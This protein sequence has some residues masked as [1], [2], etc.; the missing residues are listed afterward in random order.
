M[1][2]Q[3]K[4]RSD[5][6]KQR[7]DTVAAEAMEAASKAKRTRQGWQ[8]GLCTL[9]LFP[10]MALAEPGFWHASKEG[11]NLWILGSI[12]VGLDNFYPLPAPIE[13]A[14]KQSDVLILE[15]DMRDISANESAQIATMS[16]LPAGSTLATT[17]PPALYQQTLKQTR[18]Y[19]L[20][21]AQI[22]Q[23]QP[24]VVAITLTQQALQRAGY[25]PE[26]GVDEHFASQAMRLGT[27]IRG[28]E[29][30]PEQALAN[31]RPWV[32]AITL[33]QQAIASA[34]YQADLGV[35]EH[36][37]AQA[38]R[39]G[40]PV[41][42]LERV[43]EQL[44]YIAN[45]GAPLEQD[46]LDATIKQI[47]TMNDEIPRLMNAWFN[48]DGTTLSNILRDEQGSAA[49]QEYMERRL[50]K[51]RNH[52][53]LPKL[54]AMPEKNQFLVVGALHLYGPDG[55]LTLL[56]QQGYQLQVVTDAHE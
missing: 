32:G 28:L 3:D 49:L 51:E 46:F 43:P 17:L 34:G 30:V 45:M 10:V 5:S 23:M 56:R 26:L 11:R 36:F 29:R 48:G 15:T 55:L 16:Q 25:Q 8:K 37:A 22:N 40:M 35:D 27:P 39:T 33:T 44:A 47:D 14:W 50:L 2:E 54:L 41:R 13:Q 21:D 6:E 20:P 42:G 19:G 53:W 31:L 18:L 4:S 9:L 52:N 38:M 1:C 7:H 12:H 24:W